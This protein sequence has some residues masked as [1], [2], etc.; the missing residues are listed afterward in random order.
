[1]NKGGFMLGFFAAGLIMIANASGAPAPAPYVNGFESATDVAVGPPY[2]GNDVMFDVTR[3]TSGTGGVASA[4]G[5]WHAV[6]GSTSFGSIFTR[7]GGYSSVFPTAGYTT[8]IDVYLD[9]AESPVGSDIR[10]DWS[11]AISNP[12]GSHCRDFIFSVGT[13]GT[14]G[15]VMSASN[16]AP[17]WPANPGR[18]PYTVT[19]T[20]WY[21]LQH[22]F[23]NNAGVL[24]VDMRVLDSSGAVL[25][26]WTLSDP[27]DVIG[28]TVGGNRYGWLVTNGF[29]SL[30]LDDV[31]RSGAVPETPGD[32]KNGGW[33]AVFRADGTS[34]KNQGDCIQ[35]VNT[36]K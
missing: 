25:K 9:T 16:N 28:A 33:T 29:A 14:G 35:Y 3:V 15:F 4:S 26:S 12:A 17:G 8:S 30:E 27:S 18:D 13:N 34:F 5:S 22:V 1:M 21:T 32:C 20:G 23:R 6:A 36:G 19:T 10:F 7:Y 2:T 31:T 11:S 24:A